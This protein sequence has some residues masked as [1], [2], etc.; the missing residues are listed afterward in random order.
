MVE[1]AVVD[2][3]KNGVQPAQAPQVPGDML[4]AYAEGFLVDV[5]ADIDW[6]LDEKGMTRRE[7]AARLGVTEQRVSRI[8]SSNG[9]NLT[10]R[11][12]ARIFRALDEDVRL[13]SETLRHVRSEADR[14]KERDAREADLARSWSRSARW[15]PTRRSSGGVNENGCAACSDPHD[16]RAA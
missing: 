14:R 16:T 6:I 9:H 3:N 7:L 13:D 8:F 4:D 5:V 10:L 2:G 1:A 12:L 11:S 15:V